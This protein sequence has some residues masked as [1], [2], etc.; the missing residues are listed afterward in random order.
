MALA[1]R[2]PCET[3]IVLHRNFRIPHAVV[4]NLKVK[5]SDAIC[6]SHFTV[7]QETDMERIKQTHATSKRVHFPDANNLVLNASILHHTIKGTMS[8]VR[9]VKFPGW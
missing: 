8:I 1:L 9:S 7:I 2:P 6:G 3:T 4:K 5:C